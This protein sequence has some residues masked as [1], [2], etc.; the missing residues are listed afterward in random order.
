MSTKRPAAPMPRQ[1]QPKPGLESQMEPRPQYAA[2]KY[3]GADK[4]KGKVAIVA[5]G[6]SGIGGAVAVLDAREGADLASISPPEARRDA[7]ATRQAVEKE[8][9]RRLLLPGDVNDP[10][11]CR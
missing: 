6:D 5:G 7:E 10:R 8:G 3:R 11:W 2:P 9:R 4:L 1:E